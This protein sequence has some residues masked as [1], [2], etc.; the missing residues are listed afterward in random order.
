L[1]KQ[2][3]K[4]R[5]IYNQ[6][7][8]FI[9]DRIREKKSIQVAEVRKAFHVSDMTVRRDLA[10][11]ENAGLIVRRF[12][13]AFSPSLDNQLFRFDEKLNVNRTSKEMLCKIAATEIEENDI[14]FIDSGST[15]YYMANHLIKFE[16]LRV[17]THSLPV[18]AALAGAPKFKVTLL[19]GEYDYGR[20]AVFGSLTL[21][22]IEDFHCHKAFIGADGISIKHGLSSYYEKEAEISARILE[23]S[24]KVFVV[25]DSSKIEKDAYIKYALVEKITSIITD[26]GI[27]PEVVKIYKK[28]KITI[29]TT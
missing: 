12:G 29:R 19:G 14:I 1:Y 11:L 16:N 22:M 13:G 3:R 15:L 25:A 17:I 26:T 8:V 27:S 23:T 6:R 4:N 5:M 9:L 21:R 10:E 2:F 20:Q 18:V 24:D 7:Q 28:N